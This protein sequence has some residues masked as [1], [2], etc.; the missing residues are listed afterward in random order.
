VP[1][2][3]NGCERGGLTVDVVNQRRRDPRFAGLAHGNGIERAHHFGRIE[4][5]ERVRYRM[6]REWLAFVV[7]SE[8]VVFVA[9]ENFGTSITGSAVV[10]GLCAKDI[11]YDGRGA[12]AVIRA[13]IDR[14]SLETSAA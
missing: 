5:A 14:E 7:E 10:A 6:I 4:G 11:G 12:V 8:N 1:G 13:D 2:V 3:A 9:D